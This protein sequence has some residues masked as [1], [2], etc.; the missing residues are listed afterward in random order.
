MNETWIVYYKKSGIPY[1][2]KLTS[3]GILDSIQI[4]S[5]MH[6]ELKNI[7]KMEKIK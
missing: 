2:V 6:I 5:E 7:T 1:E 3:S 4:C